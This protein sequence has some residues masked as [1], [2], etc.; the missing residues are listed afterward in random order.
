[1]PTPI[2]FMVE[3]VVMEVM[4]TVRVHSAVVVAAISKPLPLHISMVQTLP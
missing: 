2:K 3:M 1:M 4:V